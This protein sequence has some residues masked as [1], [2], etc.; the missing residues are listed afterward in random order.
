MNANKNDLGKENGTVNGTSLANSVTS[1]IIY[2]KN[3]LANKYFFQNITI[4]NLNANN[5][6]CENSTS[7]VITSDNVTATNVDS[8]NVTTTGDVKIQGVDISSTISNYYPVYY[9]AR[10]A[11]TASNAY[12]GTIYANLIR[13]GSQV[14]V[15]VDD[16]SNLTMLNLTLVTLS[17]LPAVYR[18]TT[19]V[20]L[21]IMVR[22]G[23][24]AANIGSVC[25]IKT[26]GV[27]EVFAFYTA[28]GSWTAAGDQGWYSLFATY[29][30]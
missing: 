17:T 16:S 23:S 9:N 26:D 30:V 27:I 19:N 24:P 29:T 20:V 21:S 6:E 18:P 8:D 5:I 2:A 15:E 7:N 4:D 11:L 3:V 22:R 1:R 28:F 25:Q 10:F 13:I 14:T 12:V